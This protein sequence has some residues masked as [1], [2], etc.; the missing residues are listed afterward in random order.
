MRAKQEILKSRAEECS[1]RAGLVTDPL[2]RH[3]FLELAAQW[4]EL[5]ALHRELEA[6]RAEANGSDRTSGNN[7]RPELLIKL[8]SWRRDQRTAFE[9]AMMGEA[10]ETTLGALIRAVRN[11]FGGGVRAAFYLANPAGTAL[12]HVGW[13]ADRLC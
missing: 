10:L 12:H 3:D 2:I 5:A 11:V 9:M 6:R 4:L 1:R 8:E 7:A 13:H